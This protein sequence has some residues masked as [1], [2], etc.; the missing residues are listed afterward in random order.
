M[1]DSDEEHKTSPAR[2][3]LSI[4]FKCHRLDAGRAENQEAPD[5]GYQVITRRIFEL[6]MVV[7][8]SLLLWTNWA[9]ANRE[10]PKE[11]IKFHA[12]TD[13][14]I[15]PSFKFDL[16]CFLNT[17][18]GD[19][20]YVEYYPK[21]YDEFKTRLTP[22]AQ[23]ALADLKKKIKDENQGI[24]SA[25]LCLYFSATDD[26]TL[27]D[28]LR[29]LKNSDRMWNNL[30]QT[31]YFSDDEWRVYESV[32]LDLKTI[33]LFLKDIQFESYWTRNVLPR[34]S[35]KITEI[36][37]DLPGYN[38]IK[39][40]ETMLGFA[41]PSNQI[42]VFMLYYSQPHGIKVTGTRFLTDVAWPFEIVLRN[43]VHEMMHPPYDL[44][45]DPELK[46]TLDLLKQDQFLMDKV[47]NHD[48]AFGYNSFE[49]FMEE[50][51]VQA[52]E[53]II[54]EKLKIE[55]EAHLRWKESD[56]GMHVFAVAL[57]QVM[58][59]ENYNQKGELFRNFLVRMIVNGRLSPGNIKKIYDDFYSN[60][61]E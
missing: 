45:H 18:T 7:L 35:Q 6:G 34:V 36:K 38:V 43:A 8:C 47:V 3:M 61:E 4:A 28:M 41:L 48:P 17:L 14:Q 15:E 33:F 22:A 13:W 31:P 16:L 56:D 52:L 57:Y 26:K 51:C 32:R 40:V 27:D 21:E 37:K 2:G 42:T 39:E 19:S 25:S 9:G 50:D 53:Q 5:K 29:T 54:D 1:R 44:V 60:R 20:F 55:K 23:A 46:K 12:T 59:D 49:G 24:I 11:K 30:K 58:K 10:I